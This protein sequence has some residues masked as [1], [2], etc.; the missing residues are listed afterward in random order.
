MT[1]DDYTPE[2]WEYAAALV[3]GENPY[4]KEQS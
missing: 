1:T 4:R 2:P 3:I